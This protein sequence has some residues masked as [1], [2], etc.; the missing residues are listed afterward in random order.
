MAS[1]RKITIG[2]IK[3]ALFKAIDVAS[4]YGHWINDKSRRIVQDEP[5]GWSTRVLC[6]IHD[7]RKNPSFF[8]NMLTGQ[9][10]CH[11]CGKFG[12]FIDFYMHMNHMD[13]SPSNKTGF[14]TAIKEIS[15]FVGFDLQAFQ[16]SGG[17]PDTAI[18][19]AKE[20]QQKQAMLS[21]GNPDEDWKPKINHADENDRVTAPIDWSVANGFHAALEPDHYQYLN[22]KRGFTKATIEE[23]KIGID[24]NASVKD[25][26][27]GQYYKGRYTIPIPDKE[28][29]CRNIRCYS[30]RAE[31]QAKMINYVVDKKKATEKRYGR[32]CRL[33]NLHRLISNPKIEHVIICEGEWDCIL[34]NQMLQANGYDTWIA[35]S[36]T[37][38]ANT[39]MREWI[40]YML[41][42][43]I[44]FCLDCD[45][46][47]KLSALQHVNE[48]FLV[49]LSSG[50]F[51]AV[52]IVDIGLPG[53]KES[54]DITDF[55][56][57][58]AFTCD[59]LI[60][61]CLQTPDIH[62]GGMSNDEASID[63]IEVSSFVEAIK[64][65]EYIDKRIK[66]P[67]TI[68]ASIDKTYHA[69]RKFKIGHCPFAD[70]GECCMM[71][72]GV[73]SQERTIPYGH[74]I[75]IE[76]CMEKEV[77]ILRSIG[78][79]VCRHAHGHQVPQVVPLTKV[80]MEKYYAHQ[81]V[82][83][84][85][86]EADE[87]GRLQQTQELTQA[88]IFV[89]QPPE[90]INIEP[91]NYMATGWVRTDPKTMSATFFV[92]K[93]VGMDDD[94]KRFSLTGPQGPE[95]SGLIQEI[96]K[97]TTDEI[98]G[99][100][101]NYV[102]R[103]YESSEILYAILLTYLSPT[104]F[105]FNGS[106]L[107]GWVTTAIVGDSGTGKTETYVRFSDWINTGD[108]FS[109]LTG[110]RTG[111]LYAIKQRAG[112]WMVS[113]GRWV[114]A[115]DRIIAIDETQEIAKE[116]I[117][118]MGNAIDKGYLRVERVAS[119]GYQARVRT[120]F[121][122]NPKDKVGQAATMSDFANGCETLRNIF[123]PM[124]I[125]RL[126]MAVFVTA[127][128]KHEFY[129]RRAKISTG[130]EN[131]KPRLTAKMMRALVFWAW[132][133]KPSQ[134]IWDE[135]AVDKCLQTA[136]A[137]SNEFGDAD[138]VPLV[139]PADFRENLA[140]L[141][142]AYA[143]LDRSF[144]NKNECLRVRDDH[145]ERIGMLLQMIYSAPAC[146]LKQ[147]SKQSKGKNSLDDFEN[148]REIISAVIA[149]E[150][151]ATNPYVRQCKP[152][153]QLLTLVRDLT[154]VKQQDL[155]GQLR[156][157]PQWVQKRLATLQSL[158]LL[159]NNRY[160]YRA[161]K[162]FNLFIRE[163]TAQP[164]VERVLE[165]VREAIGKYALLQDEKND[166]NNHDIDLK[167]FGIDEF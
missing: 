143:V 167:D 42:K 17:N 121:V 152:F 111:L 13:P 93:M 118:E 9:F 110:T 26:E 18:R 128:H 123:D 20:H 12:S 11:A 23:W 120:V 154:I 73:A 159:D 117:K 145:V 131:D 102:T 51:N 31:P 125:R 19:A 83:R 163:W 85:K 119:G 80:V 65:R 138:N 56:M 142:T 44:Y 95:N 136:T 134:I 38:G 49:P 32:P 94:W 149:Q 48:H 99:E 50:N 1:D 141:S 92:E 67:L 148:I 55:F 15:K 106:L 103:I 4:Y 72:D 150:N 160:G 43:S 107:R 58:M 100:I 24:K 79:M 61:I 155:A 54:K 127:Q 77:N 153:V 64:N 140:R 133:R 34:L 68:S 101:T 161:T 74:P 25:I 147:Y 8:V 135:T 16:D 166:Y 89:L 156:M 39:F 66:V 33:L 78:K 164:D 14:F 59:R 47:G 52:K 122:M 57:K 112:E 104:R 151:V 6:P 60:D 30:S 124:F 130:N 157:P 5:S 116:Q 45:D 115:N 63:T 70:G 22:L 162:R 82:E 69:I 158:N 165:E 88:P 139:N 108:L 87:E 10:K 113:T 98:I 114:K 62:P 40:M 96:S 105:P 21:S 46:A 3:D 36:G 97:F 86:S 129:N 35:V 75:L 84:W 71:N 137:I 146:N 76:S 29:L 91:Q 144:V 37:H 126:D 7:D 81:V 132:T 53:T 109:A 41:G 2:E 27:N 90:R 28:G